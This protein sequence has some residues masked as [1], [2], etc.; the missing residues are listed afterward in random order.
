MNQKR[1]LQAVKTIIV[2]FIVLLTLLEPTVLI[3][4]KKVLPLGIATV[5]NT[6]NI[7]DI[8][9]DV[10]AKEMKSLQ[11]QTTFGNLEPAEKQELQRRIRPVIKNCQSDLEKYVAI[12]K[13]VRSRARKISPDIRSSDPLE[14]LEELEKGKGALC[15]ELACLMLASCHSSGLPAR[16]VRL[17]KEP[18]SFLDSHDTVEVWVNDEWIVMD[19]T[20]NS[21]FTIERSPASAFEIHQLLEENTNLKEKTSRLHP[22]RDGAKTEPTIDSYYIN[23]ILLY[24]H[25]LYLIES[26]YNS[27]DSLIPKLLDI[28]PFQPFGKRKVYY[29]YNNSKNRAPFKVYRMLR[30]YLNFNPLVILFLITCYI[31]LATIPKKQGEERI[32]NGS[33]ESKESN[34][35]AT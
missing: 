13:W 8:Y 28:I 6:S 10:D 20:F 5:Q 33:P 26:G 16:Y 22:V 25:T 32:A 17:L 30:I 7:K 21:Y 29:Y 2:I 23:P 1:D 18:D 11:K 35:T 31:S 4:T 12:R 34:K 3:W 14:I 15:G 9:W 24:Q 27:S 19:P